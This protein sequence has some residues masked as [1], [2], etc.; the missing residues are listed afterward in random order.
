MHQWKGNIR[1][2]KNII[3]RAAILENT[4]EVT[5]D[6]LPFDIQNNVSSSADAFDLA[7]MEKQHIQKVLTSPKATKQKR[8]VYL[9]LA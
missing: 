6:A 5:P 9:I 2:L 1:E 3:E 7:A 4:D 8:H